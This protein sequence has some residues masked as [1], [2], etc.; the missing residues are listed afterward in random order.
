M[1][2]KVT[3]SLPI[4][5]LA[6]TV[7]LLSCPARSQS[8]NPDGDGASTSSTAKDANCDSK[9]AASKPDPPV[10]RN[11]DA[12]P[13]ADAAGNDS[14]V[15]PEA[16]PSTPHSQSLRS[17]GGGGMIALGTF[18]TLAG[19]WCAVGIWAPHRRTSA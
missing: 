13:G 14:D 10:A 15:K 19:I 4:S 18:L 12:R 17:K 6:I 9:P 2:A 3:W 11:T 1:N 7:L 8:C 5:A 16:S